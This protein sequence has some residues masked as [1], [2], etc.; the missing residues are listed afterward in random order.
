MKPQTWTNDQLS[1][2]VTSHYNI[3]P[4]GLTAWYIQIIDTKAIFYPLQ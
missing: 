2:V 3:I 4:F 1:A